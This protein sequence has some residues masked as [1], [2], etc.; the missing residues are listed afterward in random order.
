[1]EGSGSLDEL[2]VSEMTRHGLT[3]EYLFK[4]AVIAVCRDE[5]SELV[6]NA[7]RIKTEQIEVALRDAEGHGRV[8]D[9]KI[10]ALM[11]ERGEKIY[12][13]AKD[14]I[15]SATYEVFGTEEEGL[16]IE[17]YIDAMEKGCT[18]K[19]VCVDIDQ[20][21]ITEPGTVIGPVRTDVL[22]PEIRKILNTASINIPTR[23]VNV[24]G[25][26]IIT[27]LK[28]IKIPENTNES[29]EELAVIQIE[30]QAEQITNEILKILG[31]E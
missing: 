20:R 5:A 26:W 14:Q 24:E 18:L 2:L 6:N 12:L 22:H 19:E 7:K 29:R 17:V 4:K 23:P 11:Q 9:G 8:I 27:I 31:I 30:K 13:D 16:A 28:E 25:I 10:K 21:R 1:M 15:T 3:K